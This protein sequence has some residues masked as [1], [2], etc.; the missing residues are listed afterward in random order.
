LTIVAPA[1]D[2][3]D[4]LGCKRYCCRRM[5]MTHVDLI[6]KL[7]RYVLYS[8]GS[9]GSFSDY[10]QIQ[11]SRARSNQSDD[12]VEDRDS[13]AFMGVVVGLISWRG[14]SPADTAMVSSNLPH[15]ALQLCRSIG[16]WR[17]YTVSVVRS[18]IAV[19]PGCEQRSDEVQQFRMT[20]EQTPKDIQYL[21]A[22]IV[23]DG[24]PMD[25]VKL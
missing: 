1:S 15:V 22:L 20:S 18:Y 3:M 12:A 2:A 8:D 21:R 7:L 6:E 19:L 11:P 9:P 16:L 25:S 4:Q 13:T 14:V 5:I 17:S 10:G 24:G 23:T